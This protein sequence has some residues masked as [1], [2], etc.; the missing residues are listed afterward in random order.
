LLVCC[1]LPWLG[2]CG[3]PGR[4]P[5]GIKISGLITQQELVS[6]RSFRVLAFEEDIYRCDPTTNRVN[7]TR[8]GYLSSATFNWTASSGDKPV[9]R[10]FL[11]AE[12]VG[13]RCIIHV[14]AYNVTRGSQANAS[15]IA[16]GC[17]AGIPI[18]GTT[19]VPA[20]VS[21]TSSK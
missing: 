15:P 11:P 18:S 16:Q 17:S 13:K 2:A 3:T 1:A 7:Y 20:S 14:E 10:L 21:I 9:L 8:T 6:I 4:P 12:I 19:A 5:V